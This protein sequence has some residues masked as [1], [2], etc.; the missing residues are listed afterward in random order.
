M[1]KICIIGHARYGKDT[2]AGILADM[3]GYI[4]MSSSEA[5]SS[6][7][8]YEALKDKYGYRT[9]I[10]CFD[11]RV[12]HRKEWFDMICEYNVNNPGRLA[13]EIMSQC[14]IYTGMRSKREIDA[15]MEKGIFDLVL[16]VYDP[17]KELED[18]S[19]FDI[20]I[21]RD[22]HI[23]VSNSSTIS[24]LTNKIFKARELFISEKNLSLPN[25]F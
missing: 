20:D 21:W 17:R 1:K 23:I 8:L 18:A 12:N 6:I 2:V 3:F 13:S 16:G 4:H 11:D 14:N 7:F 5:A 9:P 22:A 19:S 10:E 25:I 24:D 15:C